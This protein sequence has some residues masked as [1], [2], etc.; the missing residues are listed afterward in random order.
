ML[1][2]NAAVYSPFQMAGTLLPCRDLS[3]PVDSMIRVDARWI[4]AYVGAYLFWLLAYCFLAKQENWYQIM[5]AE[6][7]A[8]LVCGLCFLLIPTTNVRPVLQNDT[9]SERFLNLLYQVDDPVNLFPSIHCLE[10]WICCSAM[11][12][13]K[14]VRP[15]WRG[16]SVVL[17]ILICY[18]TL[19]TAQHVALD[20]VGGILLAEG[21][22]LVFRHCSLPQRVERLFLQHFGKN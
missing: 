17:A 18:S 7:A 19:K 15:L 20:V 22:L 1:A 12:R 10:S 4:W 21:M 5:T 14:S 11:V 6:I 16:L 8:K 2:L 9:L 13:E 3:L